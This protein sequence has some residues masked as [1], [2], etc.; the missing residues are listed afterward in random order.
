MYVYANTFIGYR[1][2]GDCY[3]LHNTLDNVR[4][5]TDLYLF[6][7]EKY[8]TFLA[9]LYVIKGKKNRDIFSNIR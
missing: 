4:N 2:E 7:Q 5:C 9:L 1:L 6:M 3:F 8:I